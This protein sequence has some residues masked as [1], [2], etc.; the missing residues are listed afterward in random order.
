MDKIEK[1]R[2]LFRVLETGNPKEGEE[3]A[4]RISCIQEKLTEIKIKR[5]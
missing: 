5:N 2:E 3:I 1:A 4:I